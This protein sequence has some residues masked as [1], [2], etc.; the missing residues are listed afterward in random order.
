MDESRAVAERYQRFADEEARGRSRLYEAFALSIAKDADCLRFLM[1]LPEAKRQPNLFLAA[2]RFVAGE[3]EDWPDFRRRFRG[4]EDLVRATMLARMTQTNEPARCAV[5]LP[6]L[7]MLPGPLSLIEVGASAGLC[8]LPDYY[9]YD[10]KGTFLGEGRPVL[11]CDSDAATPV[12]RTIPE[13]VWRA[14]LDLNPLDINDA[15]D[16]A[17]LEALVWP[18]QEERLIRLRKALEVAREQPP[19]VVRGDLRCD[20]RTLA[21]EA[22]KDATLV[23]FHTAVLSYVP[24]LEDREAFS[25]TAHSLGHWL[26]NEGAGVFPEIAENAGSAARGQMLMSLDGRPLAWTDPHGAS[27]RWIAA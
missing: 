5:L 9:A 20:L 21:E 7:A 3:P 8:L 18:E 17:W 14:G 4:N 27:I 12:P 19:R 10:Y 26:S 6:A 24:S 16:V 11:A 23:I 2:V 15:D 13:I 25:H 1:S 22:P